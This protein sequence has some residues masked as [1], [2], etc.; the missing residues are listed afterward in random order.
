MSDIALTNATA[1]AARYNL[2]IA[3]RLGHGVH[4]T[5]HVA[6]YSGK[7]DRSA[8]KA[9]G[10]VEFYERERDA[11][12]RLC[13][14]GITEILGFH[15]PTYVHSDDEFQV[16][17]MTIVTRPFVLDFAG[18]W[19]DRRP[20]F[21][22]GVWGEWEAQKREQFGAHWNTVQALLDAFEA[23][24]IYLVDVAPSNIRFAE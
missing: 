12:W 2:R 1:Y 20:Q 16:V 22:E 24:G 17:E 23:L 6:E 13:R 7:A 18:A 19:L 14:A 11:Y 10:R 9:F 5:V 4:G 8:I 3:E 21:P 15:V